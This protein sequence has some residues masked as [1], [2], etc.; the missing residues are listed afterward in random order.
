[1]KAIDLEEVAARKRRFLKRKLY[2][3]KGPNWVWH[4][5]GYDKL[6]PYGFA[7]HGCIDGYSRRVL[8]LTVLS[9]NNDPNIVCR[10]FLDEIISVGGVSRKVIAVRGTEYVHVALVQRFLCR[11][12]NELSG[13]LAQ[14]FSMENLSAFNVL[15]RFDHSCEGVVPTGGYATSDNLLTLVNTI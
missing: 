1:M 5:D 11:S 3:S 10:K 6:K 4:L 9:S 8:W 7:T 15:R 12:D 2:Y 14:H 13:V